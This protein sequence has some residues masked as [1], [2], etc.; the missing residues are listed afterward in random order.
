MIGLIVAVFAI[1]GGLY[2][3]VHFLV[4]AV[5]GVFSD[6]DVQQPRDRQRMRR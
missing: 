4:A 6:G 1:M 3:A 2:L 5:L